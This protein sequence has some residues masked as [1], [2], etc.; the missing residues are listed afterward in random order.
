MEKKRRR[1]GKRREKVYHVFL[2]RLLESHKNKECIKPKDNNQS[3]KEFLFKKVKIY[4]SELDYISR[5]IL[6]YPNIETGGQLFGL[7]MSDGTPVVC[8]AIGP[9]PNANHQPTFFNQ[10]IAYLERFGQTIIDRLGLQHIGE[11][12][13]HHQIGL[14]HPSG[15][16]A[17]T[18][19]N[20][21]KG[22]GSFLLCIGNCDSRGT[23]MLNAFAFN[24]NIRDYKKIPWDIIDNVSP[25]RTQIDYTM[26]NFPYQPHTIRSNMQ[27]L[28]T[29][30][31]P[32]Y[33]TSYWMEEKSNNIILKKIIDF[34]Q[35]H[36]KNQECMPLIDQDGY[37]HLSIRG[38]RLI[39]EIFFSK[40][41]PML[42]PQF[43]PYENEKIKWNYNGDIYQAF[44]EYYN[45]YLRTL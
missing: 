14:A 19:Y 32:I 44:V 45:N 43:K 35:S 39:N 10:D 28:Q 18:M 38:N 16:D 17:S 8:Y 7:W 31:S 2:R 15:H 40:S 21:I 29:I 27:N 25:Y 12:H 9:G 6:D 11:W 23:S 37:I 36:P 22:R 34:V 5:C 26:P 33:G 42:P 13:S 24:E 41:F 20:N 30:E 3:G 4:Q 1:N